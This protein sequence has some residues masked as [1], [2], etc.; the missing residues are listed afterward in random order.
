ML[1]LS[2]PGKFRILDYGGGDGSIA[3]QVRDNMKKIESREFELQVFETESIMDSIKKS[4]YCQYIFTENEIKGDFNLIIASAVLEHLQNPLD[5]LI[6]LVD[7]LATGGVIYIRTPYVLP[8]HRLLNKL[9][10]QIDFGFPAH[11]F[12]FSPKSWDFILNELKRSIPTLEV[13]HRN[14]SIPEVGIKHSPFVAVLTILIKLP[15][16]IGFKYWPF[17]GGLEFMLKKS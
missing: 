11:F 5:T 9:G 1:N 16:R 7:K 8:F 14:A 10:V 13:V 6:F 3:I 2:R 12:D 17:S 15:A 4:E